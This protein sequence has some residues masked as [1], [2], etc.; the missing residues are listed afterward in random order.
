MRTLPQLPLTDAQSNNWLDAH[1]RVVF[2]E[3]VLFA[4]S[5]NMYAYATLV[6]NRLPT[7]LRPAA[8]G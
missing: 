3:L 4:P 7:P 1:T 2:V 8:D 5:A 6:R